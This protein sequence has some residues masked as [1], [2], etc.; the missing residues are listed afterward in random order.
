MTRAQVVPWLL[1]AVVVGGAAPARAELVFLGSGRTLSVRSIVEDG[2]NLVLQLRT[3]GEVVCERSLVARIEPDE[4]PYPEPVQEAA[5]ESP[6]A[7]VAPEAT[8]YSQLIDAIAARHDVDAGLVRALVAT[9]SNFEPKAR[10]RKGALGLMQLMPATARFYRVSDPF[11]PAAN[12]DAGIRHLR[13]LLSRYDL[14]VAL[15]AYNAGEAA[16][17]RFGGIPPFAETRTY[18]DRILRRLGRARPPGT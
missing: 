9:E 18:V 5:G 11:D 10:S 17:Q 8:P 3:G 2:P 1:A 7:P 4:V 13:S 15:A 12:L 14:R 16:V 6:P